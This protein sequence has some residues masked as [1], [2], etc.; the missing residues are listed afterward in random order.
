M[1]RYRISVLALWFQPEVGQEGYY[2]AILADGTPVALCSAEKWNSGR[3][4]SLRAG[5]ANNIR[6]GPK[7]LT[8][9]YSPEDLSRDGLLHGTPLELRV[10]PGLY[11]LIRH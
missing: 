8:S 7:T 2:G 9:D 10:P 4:D 1:S 6:L 3:Q 5:W 11:D